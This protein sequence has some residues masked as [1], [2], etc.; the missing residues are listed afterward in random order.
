[1]W[2]HFEHIFGLVVA[3]VL[4]QDDELEFVVKNVLVWVAEMV[5]VFIWLH[6]L[7]VVVSFSPHVVLEDFLCWELGR[8]EFFVE[9]R[10]HLADSKN[11]CASLAHAQD[12]PFSQ[13][14]DGARIVSTGNLSLNQFFV[15][16]LVIGLVREEGTGIACLVNENGVLSLIFALSH[17]VEHF[18]QWN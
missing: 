10:R 5:H 9:I 13:I 16:L 4:D 8:V 2:N 15:E 17:F 1:M 18:G 3:H 11:V 14:L 12:Q 7:H 6:D